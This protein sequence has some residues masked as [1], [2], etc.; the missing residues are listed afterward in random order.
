[1]LLDKRLVI[2]ASLAQLNAE[3]ALL[4]AMPQ[5]QSLEQPPPLAFLAQEPSLQWSPWFYSWSSPLSMWLA[6]QV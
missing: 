5:F 4:P 1:L 3:E 2:A 6:G